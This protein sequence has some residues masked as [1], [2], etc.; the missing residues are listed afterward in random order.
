M[1]RVVAPLLAV[2]KMTAL[3]A[4]LAAPL[5]VLRVTS[6][7]AESVVVPATAESSNWVMESLTVVPHVPDRSPV[8]GSASPSKGEKFVTAI[9]CPLNS[10]IDIF[11][12]GGL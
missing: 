12:V 5:V 4:W 3:R 11:P 8:V 1:L 7:S 2:H 9:S 10:H 6:A